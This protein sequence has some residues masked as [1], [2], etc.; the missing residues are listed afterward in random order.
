VQRR[1][2][3]V[4]LAVDGGRVVLSGR[5]V[6]RR[7]RSVELLGRQGCGTFRRLDTARVSRTGRFRLSAAPFTGVDIASYRVRIVAAGAA[8]VR[9]G[10]PP[11]AI[12]LR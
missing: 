1:L 4:R 2:A 6:G 7:P 3:G 10:T 9:E 12:V 11:R 8:G 5:T